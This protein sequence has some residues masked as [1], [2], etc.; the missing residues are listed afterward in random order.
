MRDGQALRPWL[1]LASFTE[2]TR[3][4]FHG[5]DEEVAELARRVQ[6][7]LLTVLFGQ[8][9]LGKTSILRAGIV[10][11]LR[12]QG[13][14]PVYVRI[15]YGPAA[16]PPAQQVRKAM[17]DA[18]HHHRADA[19]GGSLWEL[20]HQRGELLFDEAGAPVKPLLIFDQFEEI[21]TLAQGDDG[22]RA[23]A[24]RFVEDLA[25]LVENRPS[26]ALEDDEGATE[27]FD[28]ARADYRVLIALRE[29][30]LAHLEG[31]KGSMPSITQNRMRLAPMTGAQALAAVAGPGRTLVSDEVA[32]AI[33]RFV[34]GGAEVAHAQVE[35][36]LL[37][38]IC[39]E[40][41]DARILAGRNEI[42]LDLLA[43]SHASILAD[44]YERAL[45]DQPNAVRQMVEDVLL[46]GS[47]YRENVAEERVQK[48]LAAAGAAPDTLAL[49]V[50]RRLL[51]IEDRL[52]IRR[53]ELTHDVLCSVVRA[54]RDAR[55]EREARA[56]AER[57]L[58]GQHEREL[59]ARRTLVRSRK[60]AAGCALLAVVAIAA[61]GFA[62]V[63]SERARQA[64]RKAEM[65]RKSAAHARAQAELLIGYLNSD[66]ATEVKGLAGKD[67]VA[68]LNKRT[69]A[70]FDGLPAIAPG[71]DTER[72]RAVAMILYGVNLRSMS[73]LDE[74]TALI[75]PAVALLEK[76]RAGGD[77]SEDTAVALGTGLLGMRRIQFAQVKHDEALSNARKAIAVLAPW[78]MKKGASTHVRRIYAEVLH[79]ALGVQGR[80]NPDEAVALYEQA[81][82]VYA[83]LGALTLADFDAAIG[84][85]AVTGEGVKVLHD[86]G[87]AD[88]DQV[89]AAAYVLGSRLLALQPGNLEALRARA[90][91]SVGLG[92]IARERGKLREAA[93]NYHRAQ[94][95]Y[96]SLARLDPTDTNVRLNLAGS[97]VSN[98]DVLYD[99]G[100]VDAALNAYAQ[101][102]AQVS[103]GAHGDSSLMNVHL[104]YLGTQAEMQ[105]DKGAGAA[106]A[107]NLALARQARDQLITM[108]PGNAFASAHAHCRYVLYAARI[109]TLA[110]KAQ[111][112]SDMVA[113]A[114]GLWGAV[115]TKG[116]AEDKLRE[117]CQAQFGLASA[118]AAYARRD[119]A[120][121]IVMP[122]PANNSSPLS[123]KDV[124]KRHRYIDRGVLLA[125]G[126]AA[127]GDAAAANATLAPLLQHQRQIVRE[128]PESCLQR[129]RLASILFAQSEASPASAA[130]LRRE[131]LALIEGLPAQLR[132]TASVQ[133]WRNRILAAMPKGGVA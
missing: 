11:R 94:A 128:Q 104:N 109:A 125:L 127:T 73:R 30:Y 35:P 72:N 34:A 78:A 41:N 114:A 57:A 68:G 51:R 55:Q 81:R 98:A 46:T 96:R 129:V 87:R 64:E 40:L 112:A 9:G 110:G 131:A 18:A 17:L 54:S 59:A 61:A 119:F 21:F 70:Y 25:E 103:D 69:L 37:S 85:V 24:A 77:H 117:R 20:L 124:F 111:E 53:V 26:K 2:E 32:A 122:A 95:D 4:N 133:L 16:P 44:F 66:F 108:S 58:A 100:Q 15:D 80:Y 1:G 6:R 76:R 71:S 132:A 23:R 91:V 3:A 115:A 75:A 60:I 50:N 43:G 36:S 118:R 65:T 74:A 39:R 10:P 123:D 79:S 13:Y 28:F 48:A 89:G 106:S 63:A 7:K 101:A 93:D 99:L 130:P 107:A 29:D 45:E 8:S 12:E 38:L 121:M 86:A 126:Q 105:A 49:L 83:G 47:G 97:E 27:R 116:G 120:S 90:Y 84:Y 31:L 67:V 82:Q 113:Q 56:A 42:T 92:H 52:D 5:R 102:D 22:G 33:V 62:Y 14:C 19:A 88:A